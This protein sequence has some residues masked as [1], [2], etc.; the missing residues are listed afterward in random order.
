MSEYQLCLKCDRVS[1]KRNPVIEQYYESS[2]LNGESKVDYRCPFNN[3]K[4]RYI[5]LWDW[6]FIRDRDDGLPEIPSED[7][8]FYPFSAVRLGFEI[9][10][11]D[12]AYD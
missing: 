3:C 2:C 11:D 9:C 1:K 6:D 12:E 8:G 7:E 5:W 4:A 10:D